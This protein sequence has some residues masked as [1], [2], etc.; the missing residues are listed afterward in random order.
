MLQRIH[1]YAGR[2]V[3][4]IILALIALSFVFW[5]VGDFTFTGSTFAAKVNGENVPLLEFERELQIQQSQYQQLYRVEL[6]E[7]M[8]SELRRNVL[9]RMVGT[10]ALEQRVE[11]AGYRVSDERLT[12]YVRSVAAFQVD[13]EFSMSVYRGRL[14][15]Q[16]LTATGFEELQRQQLELRELQDGIVD[17]AFLTPAEFRRY[18]ELSRQRREIAYAM[19]EVD[20]FIDQVEVTD[21][22]IAAHYEANPDRYMTE[23]TVDLEYLELALDDI[24]ATIE[25]TDEALRDYYE[26]E[27]ERFQTEEERRARHILIEVEDSED[28]ALSA[29]EAVVARL[30]NGEDFAMLA[31]ELSDDSGTSE[32]GGDL[33]WVGRGMLTGPLED[34]LFEMEAG[35]VRGPVQTNFGYHVIQLD[36]IRAGEVQPFEAVREELSAEYRTRRAE[37]SFYE[38][39]NDL[40]DLA[41]QA[42]D[43]LATVAADMDL[44]LEKRSGFPR[45]G[46]SEI[47]P[48]SAP[49]VQ[50]AFSEEALE[51]SNNSPLVEISDEHVLVLRVTGHNL[52]ELQPLDAV[53]DEVRQELTRDLAEQQAEQAAAA[54]FAELEEGEA[55]ES[56]DRAALAEAHGG[57]WHQ[58]ARV[59]R[60]DPNVPT[61]VLATAFGLPKPAADASVREHLPLANGNHA[62]LILTGVE[63]GSP[64][65]VARAERDQQQRELAQQAA[66]AEL[67]GYVGNV[68]A[69]ATVRI[70]E[71]VLEPARF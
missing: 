59:E 32:Q 7:D 54:F 58:P 24:A 22:A 5:G 47:F 71:E 16:G 49:V 19:F 18:L 35:E 56:V 38:R 8:R 65:A 15:N 28:A 55:P 70:P 46:D 48:N 44:M 26:A 62:V 3:V 67:A 1:D 39:A 42:Y 51:Q 52:P 37:E 4:G 41:F 30:D 66:L 34:V 23:E 69:S 12:D 53:Y 6:T 33:G 45:S 13:G 64:E 63:P 40:A 17:S 68:R 60:T 9:E 31:Q 21:E 29:A 50:A 11:S 61:E 25:V 57:V 20:S 14:A 43:E 27:R 2:W 36:E 10:E